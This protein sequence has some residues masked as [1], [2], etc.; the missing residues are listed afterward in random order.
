MFEVVPRP[1]SG[2]LM[3]QTMDRLEASV[4][5]SNFVLIDTEG[6]G[7]KLNITMSHQCDLVV[8]PVT[9]DAVETKQAASLIKELRLNRV[10]SPYR[11]I[12]NRVPSA[13]MPINERMVREELKAANIP[14]IPQRLIERA[15]FKHMRRESAGLSDFAAQL[16]QPEEQR[17]IEVTST[18]KQ[19]DAALENAKAVAQGIIDALVEEKE[20]A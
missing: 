3:E 11:L 9:G 5:R 15:I 13:I 14:L 20:N 2:N 7:D 8:I 19:I 10:A 18:R 6:I 16:E 17:I 1:T 4:T 12:F